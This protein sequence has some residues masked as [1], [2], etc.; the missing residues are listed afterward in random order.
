MSTHVVTGVCRLSY[1][2]IWEAASI[3]GSEPKY[4]ACIIVPKDDTKTIS[5]I[6]SAVKEAMQEGIASKWKGKKPAKLKLPLRDG[7]EERPDDSAFEGSYFLNANSQ[8]QPGVVDR[9]VKPILDP[10]IVYSGCYCKFSLSFYPYSASGNNGV[11]C[12]LNNIQFIRDGER[13]A[14]GT[15]PEQ[16]FE[17]MEDQDFDDFDI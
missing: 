3:N 10:E 15:T 14:G 8:R 12:G 11:A 6:E 16:D 17:A 5:A 4:S 9:R 13:L 7:D 1:S 2:H